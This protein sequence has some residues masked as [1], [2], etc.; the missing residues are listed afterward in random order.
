M[1]VPNTAPAPINVAPVDLDLVLDDAEGREDLGDVLGL[2]LEGWR[3]ALVDLLNE[4]RGEAATINAEIKALRDGRSHQK[5]AELTE[6][7]A[8]LVGRMTALES[9]MR[10]VKRLQRPPSLQQGGKE[11]TDMLF[12]AKRHLTAALGIL[13]TLT[14]MERLLSE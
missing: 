2:N 10:Q 12:D 11:T 8:A 5:R 14:K 9:R 6:E 13:N 7:R 3:C 4:C 1:H